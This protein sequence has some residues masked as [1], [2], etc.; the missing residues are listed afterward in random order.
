MNTDWQIELVPITTDIKSM[1]PYLVHEFCL[2]VF[3]T[4]TEFY[5]KIG[6]HLPWVGYFALYENEV[7]GV[8]GYKGAPKNQK[9]EIAYGSVVNLITGFHC[10]VI[11]LLS[12][13]L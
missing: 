6:F 9:V 12:L 4:F 11:T 3:N 10:L 5:P 13:P 2:E 1:E 7:V 8:G